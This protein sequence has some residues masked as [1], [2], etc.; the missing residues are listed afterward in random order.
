MP[1]LTYLDESD[2]EFLIAVAGGLFPGAPAFHQDP[3]RHG[4]LSSAMAV[5][6]QPNYPRLP[7][8][9]AAL[10]YHLNMNH[11]FIDGN[12]RFAVAAME[13]FLLINDAALL[14]PDTRI[15]DVSLAVASHEWGK[16]QLI[17]FVEERTLRSTWSDVR[18]ATWFSRLSTDAR[19]DVRE[20]ICEVG[21]EQEPLYRRVVSVLGSQFSQSRPG[22][23][24]PS[25]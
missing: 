24:T 20:A 10:Q 13:L 6:R 23:V 11:P 4:L 22:G 17:H 5:P 9:A 7:A 19:A 16:E 2:T 1:R 12:K 14:A 15:V 21:A 8:K 3:S 18:L 25:P